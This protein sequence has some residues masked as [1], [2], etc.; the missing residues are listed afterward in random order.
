MQLKTRQI[1]ATLNLDCSRRVGLYSDRI[2]FVR[3]AF[4]AL[5]DKPTLVPPL[6][7]KLFGEV[8]FSYPGFIG[9]LYAD[10]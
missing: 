9:E 3:F 6:V 4:L 1:V 5:I 2:H 7:D 8:M 10:N